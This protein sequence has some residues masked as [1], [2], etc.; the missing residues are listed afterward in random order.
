MR[1]V[2]WFLVLL[3]L[4]VHQDVWLWNNDHLV[5]GFIPAGL[6]YHAGLSIAASI[7]WLLAVRFAWP[8]QLEY[9][10]PESPAMT[11]RPT[12]GGGA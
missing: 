2:I 3:M 4:V 6:A 5:F 8:S 11:S 10:E 12:Q 7:V 1:T 9:D